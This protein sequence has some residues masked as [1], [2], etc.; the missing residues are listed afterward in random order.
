MKEWI[1]VLVLSLATLC[2]CSRHY[3]LKLNNG[4]QI[5]SI[6]KP[7]LKGASYHYKDASGRERIIPQ[8]RV[9]EI[10]PASMAKEEKE[11]FKPTSK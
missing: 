6:G 8:G 4:S 9:T 7:K 2:G 11:M 10:M 5:T 1:L 3:I